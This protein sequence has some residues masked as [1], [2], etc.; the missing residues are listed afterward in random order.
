MGIWPGSIWRSNVILGTH[1]SFLPLF[2]TSSSVQTY[3]L[4]RLAETKPTKIDILP[5][6][7]GPRTD[8]PG[9]EYYLCE[10]F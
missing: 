10:G 8:A 9:Q 7:T 5:S 1:G 2:S 4:A 3:I 6:A